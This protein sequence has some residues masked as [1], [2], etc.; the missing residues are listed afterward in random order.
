M[1]TYND[2]LSDYITRTFA[3]EDE[4]L[5]RVRRQI[6]ERGLPQIMLRPEEGAFLRFLVAAV[7]ARRV[8]EIGTLGGYSA[9]WMARGLPPEG[10]IFTVE[11]EP[12][13]AAV[14]REHFRLAGVEDRVEVREG[15]ARQVLPT[16]APEGPFDLVFIDA[17]KEGY[18][19]YLDWA[20]ENLRPGG[21]V[22]AHNAFG[23]GGK[24]ADPNNREPDVERIRAFNRRLAEDPRLIATIFPAGD[25][26][27]VAV[28]RG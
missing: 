12:R 9:I 26:T 19:A 10:R 27:A 21:V 28:L 20:L 22:A 11:K 1:P 5:A 16:L 7:G 24:I 13:H 3:A 15:D 25:G 17:D 8:V 4:V 6:A 14:A 18:L 2:A 23:F